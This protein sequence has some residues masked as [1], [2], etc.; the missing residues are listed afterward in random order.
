MLTAQEVAAYLLGAFDRE[1]GDNIT[2]MKLQKLLYY[3]QGFHAAMHGGAALFPEPIEAWQYGPLVP[4]VYE[5]YKAFGSEAIQP[6]ADFDRGGYLPEI[7]E[8]LDAVNEVYGQ[9]GASGLCK[10][11]HTETPWINAWQLGKTTP[12]P[13]EAI[14]PYFERLV[15]AGR[16]GEVF[17]GHPVWPANRFQHQRRPAIAARFEGLRERSRR[18]VREVEADRDPWDG[19]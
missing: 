3:A 4:P 5:T 9:Y 14:T 12:I 15:A 2:N 13:L 6:P 19:A 17:E 1:A 10:L 8:L 18:L 16:R 7:A 11:S